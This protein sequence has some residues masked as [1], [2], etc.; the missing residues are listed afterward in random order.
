MV[1]AV[2]A[3]PDTTR[4]AQMGKVFGYLKGIHAA[5]LIDI[6]VKLGLFDHLAQRPEGMTPEALATAARLHAPYVRSWCETAC[7]LEL[8][9][10]APGTGYRFAP[11]M[12]ELL[13][14]P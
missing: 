3:S 14:Q 11:F 2:V 13:G 1:P 6:G 12:D 4:Q 8:L 5:H 10:Y 9:D 7:G